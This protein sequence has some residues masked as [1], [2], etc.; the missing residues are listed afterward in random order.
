[1][2]MHSEL[3][4]RFEEFHKDNPHVYEE[5]VRLA[6]EASTNGHKRIGIRMIWEVLRW[7]L[8]MKTLNAGD[9]KLNN[10]YHSRYARLVMERE[11]D[12]AGVFETRE[13][14]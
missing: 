12:L 9:F 6:R 4:S 7:N 8:T 5:L 10:N 13:R 14:Q 3:Q 1:M 11:P 2:N